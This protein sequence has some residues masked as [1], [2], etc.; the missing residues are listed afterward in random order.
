MKRLSVILAVAILSP[1]PCYSADSLLSPQRARSRAAL[2]AA[3][4]SPSPGPSLLVG[5]SSHPDATSNQS[6]TDLRFIAIEIEGVKFWL[7]GGD[8]DV[9]FMAQLSGGAADE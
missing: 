5:P 8:I 6:K 9:P 4:A 1:L 2:P 7:G 3:T